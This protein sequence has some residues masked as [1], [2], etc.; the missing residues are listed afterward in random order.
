[1]KNDDPFT[2]IDIAGEPM[3]E[4]RENVALYCSRIKVN[5][6]VLLYESFESFG[7]ISFRRADIGGNFDASDSRLVNPYGKALSCESAHI[8]G[9]LLLERNFKAMGEVSFAGAEIGGRVSCAG[10]SLIIA[11]ASRRT[12]TRYAAVRMHSILGAP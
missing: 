6:S 5:G 11:G 8:T 4:Y 10:G 3:H 7:E 1:M 12:A 2:K 9:D